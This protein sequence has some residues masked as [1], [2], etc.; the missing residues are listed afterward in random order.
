MEIIILDDGSTDGTADI[1]LLAAGGDAHVRIL[2]GAQLPEG[3]KGKNWACHQ[4]AQ[5]ARGDILLFTDADVL[6][7]P[8]ALVALIG[9]MTRSRA[10]ML[11][12]WPT[13]ITRTWTER[14]VVPLVGF[15]IIS[16][17]P[18]VAVH[19]TP[20]PVFSAA[21]G[22]CLAFRRQSYMSVGGHQAVRNDMLEDMAFGRGIKRK[23]MRLRLADGAGLISTRMY[24]SWSE[25]RDGFAKNIL[26]G[27][28]NNLAFLFFSTF[29]HW[30][31]FIFPWF[32]WFVN[33][34]QAS[35]LC[36]LGILA[37]AL[38]AAVTRQRLVDA[39]LLPVSVILMTMI[40][41]HA[42]KWHFSGGLRWKGRIYGR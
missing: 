25:V 7:E 41:A 28:G 15:V 35:L 18:L 17:L 21:I 12:I 16:Y 29:F 1:A 36:L 37:R 3:W 24:R 32:W 19:H 9:E 8:D 11:T 2:H 33:P 23:H 40:V 39:L 42:L 10:D 34:L 13:Q 6:W 31:L 4:L 27:H 5:V 20:W 38:S 26:G 22:Q 30:S 14:L